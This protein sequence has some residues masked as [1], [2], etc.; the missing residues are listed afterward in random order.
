MEQKTKTCFDCL[1]CKVS[2]NKYLSTKYTDV[3]K[4]WCVEGVFRFDEM[5]TEKEMDFE[6]LPLICDFFNDMDGE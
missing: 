4:C 3:L 1:N 5:P 2:K 6:R